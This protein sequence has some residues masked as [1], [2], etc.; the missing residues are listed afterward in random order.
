MQITL[1]LN[2]NQKVIIRKIIYANETQ[3]YSSYRMEYYEIV[4]CIVIWFVKC[5]QHDICLVLEVDIISNRTI[6]EEEA[7]KISLKES[8]TWREVSY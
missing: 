8:F 2:S 6:Q 7:E 5:A 3:L 1:Y 4:T